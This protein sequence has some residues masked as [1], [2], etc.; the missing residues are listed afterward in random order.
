MKSR[1]ALIGVGL[2]GLIA[3]G[4]YLLSL[5]RLSAELEIMANAMVH[6]VSLTG[7]KLRVDVTLKNPT[8]GTVKV[9]YPFVK[10]QYGESTFA[11]SQV[12]NTDFELPRYGEK[13]LEPIYIDLSFVSLGMNVPGLLKEYRS[14]GNLSFALKT[15]TTLNGKIPY[16]KTDNITIGGKAGG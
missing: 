8:G 15:V 2:I 1:Q 13:T 6:Q 12:K 14:S 7:L 4:A 11:S 16:S 10:L 3:G 9:K 5:G